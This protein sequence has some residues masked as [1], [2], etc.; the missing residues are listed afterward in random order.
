MPK[1]TLEA[2]VAP[3]GTANAAQD[4][5]IGKA[6]FAGRVSA[7]KI[8]PE[9]A[10]TANATNFR[11]FRVVNKGQNGSG[12][13]S[14]VVASF[15][16]DT[17]TTDDLAAFD[18]KAI[19]LSG[20]ARRTSTSPKGDVLA[21]DETV[22]GQVRRRPTRATRS[23]SRSAAAVQP[24]RQWRHR[25]SRDRAQ[26]GARHPSARRD[27]A[28]GGRVHTRREPREG[29]DAAMTALANTTPA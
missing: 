26:D 28:K 8:V 29:L 21:V 24:R 15:A 12:S 22:A 19:P 17:P 25:P 13:G 2:T 20:T 14:T 7:V 3:Q 6:P 5:V 16:T 18:E 10:L 1:R 11:T 9:A 4:Q 23:S 27:A